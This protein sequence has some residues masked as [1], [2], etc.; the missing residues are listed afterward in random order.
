MLGKVT[1][2]KISNL[3]SDPDEDTLTVTSYVTLRTGETLDLGAKENT[4]WMTFSPELLEY[5]ANP[6]VANITK[7][8]HPDYN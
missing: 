5:T 3:F 6:A 2:F 4:F 7:I 8:P 1:V